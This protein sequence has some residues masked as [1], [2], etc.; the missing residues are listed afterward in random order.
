MQLSVDLHDVAPEQLQL[1][2]PVRM[3]R[4]DGV[5]IERRGLVDDQFAR[6]LPGSIGGAVGRHGLAPRD[7]P[8]SFV[9]RR[10][11]FAVPSLQR[12]ELRVDAAVII[13]VVRR[14]GGEYA[15][16]SIHLLRL[17]R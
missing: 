10:A 12:T 4:H 7:A 17:L 16:A 6:L 13:V 9:R 3:Q 14:D 11:P 5:V 15:R 8:R 2:Q 1:R